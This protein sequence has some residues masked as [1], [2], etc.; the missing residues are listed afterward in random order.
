MSGRKEKNSHVFKE[1]MRVSYVR[2]SYYKG[3]YI[4][5]KFVY[6]PMITL[7]CHR[8]GGQSENAPKKSRSLT[9]VSRSNRR[10]ENQIGADFVD[11]I[12]C[13]PNNPHD[14]TML[15]CLSKPTEVCSSHP[16]TT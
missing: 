2:N 3:I 11:H 6:D 9:Q 14:F 12:N 13:L 7:R 15:S 8:D 4:I 10:P 5:N 16:S 1:R